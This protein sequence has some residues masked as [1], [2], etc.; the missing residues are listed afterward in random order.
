LKNRLRSGDVWVTGSRQF[1]DFDAYLLEPSRFTE[2]RNKQGLALPI[3]QDGEAYVTERVA[4]LKQS[5]D[6]VG[7]LAARGELPDAAVSESG[8]KIT[9]LTN[10]VPEQASVLMRRAYTLLAHSA[11]SG[12]PSRAILCIARRWSR[13]R[14]RCGTRI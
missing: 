14:L 11:N 12:S 10:T 13:K 7:G 4:L 5:L 3:Q 9:P 8:L 2:L 1:K 6:E